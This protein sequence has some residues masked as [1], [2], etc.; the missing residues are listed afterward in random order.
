MFN[1]FFI[2]LLHANQLRTYSFLSLQLYARSRRPA[3][4][5]LFLQARKSTDVFTPQA[6]VQS[7]S[8]STIH[9]REKKLSL[10]YSISIDL[11]KI[12]AYVR[13]TTRYLKIN[14]KNMNNMK[15][16]ILI[17]SHVL[18]TLDEK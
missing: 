18:C 1:Y 13:Y 17:F 15:S 8:I 4:G 6:K 12:Y 11:N 7:D 14:S 2:S 5:S 9:T 3:A 10:L 16:E